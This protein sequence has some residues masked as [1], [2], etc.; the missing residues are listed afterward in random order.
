MDLGPSLDTVANVVNLSA[1]LKQQSE[2]LTTQLREVTDKINKAEEASLQRIREAQT[3]LDNDM[4]RFERLQ[5]EVDK[6]AQAAQ[7]KIR[8]NIGGMLFC[9]AK[10]TLLVPGSFFHAM[11]GSDRWKPDNDSEYFVDR[12][13]ILFPYVLTYLRTGAWKI[14]SLTREERK[15]LVEEADFYQLLTASLPIPFTFN[16]MKCGPDILLSNNYTT[17]TGPQNTV[18]SLE[19]L[20]PGTSSWKIRIDQFTSNPWTS[21][22]IATPTVS[23]SGN[24][25]LTAGGCGL[26]IDA[27]NCRFQSAGVQT[28]VKETIGVATSGKIITIQVDLSK[29]SITFS[30]DGKTTNP[31]A[32][33]FSGDIYAAISPASGCTFSFV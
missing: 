29:P 4:Q 27:N 28:D 26:Y 31:F 33:P 7:D 22:G 6:R 15:D 1:Q 11:L 25:S 23:L 30:C 16:P 2:L 14:G 13:P 10:E 9:V 21:I 18:L 32:I 24:F 12:D 20:P 17:C 5:E 8:L 19:P 3:K